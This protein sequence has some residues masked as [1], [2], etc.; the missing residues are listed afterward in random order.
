MPAAFAVGLLSPFAGDVGESAASFSGGI[1]LNVALPTQGGRAVV[2]AANPVAAIQAALINT[3]TVTF[4][5]QSAG[6]TPGAT[7]VSTTTTAQVPFLVVPTATP[8]VYELRLEDLANMPGVP[9]DWDYNDRTWTVSVTELAVVSVTAATAGEDTP[10]GSAPA[11]FTLT[12]SATS[13]DV[14]SGPLVVP[15]T[16]GG[17]AV[18]GVDYTPPSAFLAVFWPG[19]AVTKVVLPVV[20]DPMADPTKTIVITA[21]PVAGF[22][23]GPT[24]TV[25]TTITDPGPVPPVP[26][27]PTAEVWVSGSLDGEER[28]DGLKPVVFQLSRTNPS[29]P[30]TAPALTVSF[31]L[32]GVAIAGTDYAAPGSYTA[33]FAPGELMT[34]VVLRVLEDE[35]DEGTETADLTLTSGSSY[36]ITSGTGSGQAT[37]FEPGT[38]PGVQGLASVS[39]TVWLDQVL[40]DTRDPFTPQGD[41]PLADV[42]VYLL[43]GSGNVFLSTF[44]DA[45]GKYSFTRLPSGRY[46][47]EVEGDVLLQFVTKDVGSESHDCDVGVD[48]R[49]DPF[50]LNGT[51][52]GE[53]KVDAGLRNRPAEVFNGPTVLI[54]H[55]GQNQN[56]L[57]VAKWE[58]AFAFDKNKP[59]E[60]KLVK[61]DRNGRDFIDRDSDSF[62]VRV[63][64]PTVPANQPISVWISTT[65]PDLEKWEYVDTSTK[66]T[67]MPMGNQPGWFISDSQMLVSNEVDDKYSQPAAANPNWAGGGAGTAGGIR[68]DNQ[69]PDSNA[70]NSKSLGGWDYDFPVSDRTHIVALGGQVEAEYANAQNP[71]VKDVVVKKTVKLHVNVLMVPKTNANGEVIPGQT[72]PA[73]ANAV[74]EQDVRKMREI[75]AQ[76]GLDVQFTTYPIQVTPPPGDRYRL[77][78]NGPEIVDPP[79][80]SGLH[81]PKINPSLELGGTVTTPGK[82][83]DDPS[84]EQKA[85]LGATNL[86]TITQNGKND[87]EVYYV[88]RFSNQ[89]VNGFSLTR[90]FQLPDNQK[91]AHTVVMPRVAKMNSTVVANTL[92][93]VVPVYMT[94]AHEVAHVL[95]SGRNTTDLE[96]FELTHY[97]YTG[98]SAKSGQRVNLL[99]TGYTQIVDGKGYVLDEDGD[100]DLPGG[101][102]VEVNTG[103]GI[104][105][106]RRLTRSQEQGDYNAGP[107]PVQRVRDG[108]MNGH[109]DL[110]HGD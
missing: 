97:P 29:N 26:P 84:D 31:T 72:E 56:R 62:Y 1:S 44:T 106:S 6:Y 89:F 45:N 98:L 65:H 21:D 86:R 101:K 5:G 23:P 107:G 49:S 39:G 64:D 17:T 71:A 68:V 30:A 74:V 78:P 60:V 35:L 33:T 3:V 42:R 92:V 94:L 96:K 59:N 81:T 77:P 12:R 108:M 32:S 36:T 70:K 46:S 55:L 47:V 10:D 109:P 105:D 40:N 13:A 87:V 53:V 83:W 90:D 16:L 18:P 48:G 50:E 28:A 14:L 57:Q 69:Q 66:V 52:G 58:R 75:Y 8:G 80:G 38:L 20:N 41:A 24:T 15:F 104:F 95:E 51:T 61:P 102:A 9:P 34:T 85:L 19:Q 63:Y 88:L 54:D 91:Y 110:L 103:S 37:I 76:I 2:D 43:D 82:M 67:L 4:A 73:V 93:T 25:G 100:I 7:T 99:A 79:D 27:A 11:V 22:V